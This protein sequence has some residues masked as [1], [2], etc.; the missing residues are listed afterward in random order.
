MNPNS[1]LNPDSRGPDT[2][3]DARPTEQQGD[4]QAQ[5]HP[6]GNVPEQ[7]GWP[8]VGLPV[9]DGRPSGEQNGEKQ[10]KWKED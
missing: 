5:R 6:E 9:D 3:T 7:I 10:G 1:P 8:E 2:R 4:A